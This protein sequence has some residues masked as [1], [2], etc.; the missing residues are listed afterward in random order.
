M[1]GSRGRFPPIRPYARV[2]LA[3]ADNVHHPLYRIFGARDDDA[4]LRPDAFARLRPPLNFAK[5]HHP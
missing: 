4:V 1:S 5:L 3:S 2:R